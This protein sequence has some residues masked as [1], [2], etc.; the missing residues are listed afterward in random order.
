MDIYKDQLPA[1]ASY[2]L[3]PSVLEAALQT[4]GVQTATALY[5]WRNGWS[6]SGVLFQADFYPPGRYY[7]NH[8]ELLTVR[9][10]A[11]PSPLRSEARAFLEGSVLPA[12][13]KWIAGL[14][15]LPPDSTLRREK[16]SFVRVWRP[17]EDESR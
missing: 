2:A 5:Q 11:V 4:G 13:V 9:S 8:D 10:R 17:E 1:G 6:D 3:K 7:R 16:Q 12:F 15:S 14:E